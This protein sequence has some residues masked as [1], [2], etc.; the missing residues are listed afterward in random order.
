MKKGLVFFLSMIG[1]LPVISQVKQND[2]ANNQAITTG[3]TYAVVIGIAN[4]ENENINLNYA[5]RDAEVFAGYLQSKAGGAVPLEN[6]RLLIDTNATTSAIYNVLSWLRNR[7][8]EDKRENSDK[9]N[10]VYFYFS[11]HGDVETDT[12]AN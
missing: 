3:N 6:I 8:E 4:Y 12:R 10:L 2:A 11:G 9:T 5:N 1:W 7:C